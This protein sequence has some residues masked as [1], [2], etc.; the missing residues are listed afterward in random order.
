MA[1]ATVSH[2]GQNNLTGDDHA[3]FLKMFAGETITA[4]DE[5]NVFLG[6]HKIRNIT[7]GKSA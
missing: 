1:D 2:L 6:K 5:K 3:L 4:F 7:S